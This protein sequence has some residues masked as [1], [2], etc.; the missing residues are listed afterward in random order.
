MKSDRPVTEESIC[1]WLIEA[2][3]RYVRVEASAVTPNTA[4]EEVGLSSLAA[5]TLSAEMADFFEIEVDPLVTWE[6]PTIAE[7]A[8]AVARSAVTGPD[9]EKEQEVA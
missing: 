5:V 4:F 9:S 3:A 7:T 8:G 2:V 6:H 1:S